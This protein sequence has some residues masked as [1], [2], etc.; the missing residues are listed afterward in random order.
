MRL[1]CAGVAALHGG[2]IGG[3]AEECAGR[4]CN[5]GAVRRV[6][7]IR[8]DGRWQQI[9]NAIGRPRAT[10]TREGALDLARYLYP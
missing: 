1:R 8:H 2:V 9:G 10:P 5:G 7:E 6:V 4:S 3:G